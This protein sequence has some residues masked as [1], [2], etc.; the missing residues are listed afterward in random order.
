MNSK[1]PMIPTPLVAH[2]QEGMRQYL[3]ASFWS[4]TPSFKGCIDR[5]LEQEQQLFRGPYLSVKLPFATSPVP[6]DFFPHL[7]LT[8]PPYVHQRH[9]YARLMATP[10]RSTI[11]A[12]GTGSGKTESFL[13]PI[14]EHCAS[15]DHHSG[16]K[17]II[18]YPMN[19]LATDQARRIAKL[20]HKTTSLKGVR[21]G[22]YVGQKEDTPST[23]MEAN[24]VITDRNTLRADPPD[25]LL[26][27]YKM[28]DYLLLRPEDK[29]LWAKNTPQTLK[30]LVVDELHTFDGAQGTDLACLLRRLR[31]RLQV[32]K[33]QLCCV[34]T[35]ATLG[36][37]GDDPLAYPRAIFGVDFE[38]YVF[39]ESSDAPPIRVPALIGETRQSAQEFF[40]GIALCA[41]PSLEDLRDHQAKLDP[42]NAHNEEE[43]LRKQIDLWFKQQILNGEITL[44]QTGIGID[45]ESLGQLLRQL[46]SFRSLM[47][48]LADDPLSVEQAGERGLHRTH[49]ES[50]DE[51]DPKVLQLIVSSLI[52]M[53]AYARSRV[54]LS[55]ELDAEDANEAQPAENDQEENKQESQDPS[56]KGPLAPLVLTQVQLWQR[57]LRRM[58]ATVEEEPKLLFNDDQ[59]YLD[60]SDDPS[61]S[62]HLN[63]SQ[64]NSNYIQAPKALPAIRCRECGLMGWATILHK[65][66][67]NNYEVGLDAFIQAFFRNDD[68]VVYL[69]PH[70]S[71]AGIHYDK[72][73]KSLY[74]LDSKVVTLA[75]SLPDKA[76]D[77]LWVE[78][79]S[80]NHKGN[81]GGVY[82][83]KDCPLCDARHSLIIVGARSATLTSTHIN[84]LFASSFNPDK[85]LLAF[86][87]SVQD[88]AHRAGFIEARTWRFNLRIA[89]MQ[90]LQTYEQEVSLNTF[91]SDCIKQQCAH[92]G[93]L[94]FI[95][96][97]TPDNMQDDQDFEALI[98]SRDPET[99]NKLKKRLCEP[100]P[101]P[102]NPDQPFDSF[103]ELV[104]KRF[105][106]EVLAEFGHQSTRGRALPAVGAAVVSI[107]AEKLEHAVQLL[108]EQ[109]KAKLDPSHEPTK[110]AVRQ[111]VL[112]LCHRLIK[113]GAIYQEFYHDE[114]FKTLGKSTYGSFGLRR[115]LPN[116]MRGYAPTFLSNQDSR[117]FDAIPRSDDST[118]WYANWTNRCFR[119]VTYKFTDQ[120][121]ISPFNVALEVLSSTDVGILKF[122]SIQSTQQNLIQCWG[123]QLEALEVSTYPVAFCD[124]QEQ[125]F[126]YLPKHLKEQWLDAPAILKN[127][128][129]TLK[130]H[131]N[132][133]PSYFTE[134]FKSGNVQRVIAREHTGLLTRKTR[135]LTEDLFKAEP[136]LPWSP[137]LLSCTP[138][139][140]MGI[141]IGDLSSTILCSVPPTTSSFLQRIGRAGRRDGNALILTIANGRTHDQ[142][143]FAKPEEMIK[144][145]VKAPGIFLEAAAVL[146]R[147]LTAFCFDRWAQKD[148]AQLPRKM[149]FV[150]T[151]LSQDEPN[152]T[153]FPYSL[154]EYIKD[155]RKSLFDEFIK[156][157]TLES[158]SSSSSLSSSSSS[159]HNSSITADVY[160][161]LSQFIY[162]D[163]VE[164]DKQNQEQEDNEPANL[165]STEMTSPLEARI[166]NAF[167]LRKKLLHG[168]NDD[169]KVIEQKLEDL[170]AHPAPD[171]NTKKIMSELQQEIHGLKG[172]RY[173]LRDKNPL[174]DLSDEGLLPNYAFPEEGVRLKSVIWRKQEYVKNEKERYK[175]VTYEFDRP[176]A[177]ALFEFAPHSRF[178]A[179]QRAV[180]VDRIDL[181]TS[182]IEQ[183][184]FCSQCSHI[185][186]KSTVDAQCPNCGASGFNDVGQRHEML[187]IKQVYANTKDTR[188]RIRDDSDERTLSWYGRQTLVDVQSNEILFTYGTSE[189]AQHSF[190]YEYLKKCT[191]RDIN[192][193][194]YA[195]FSEDK[196]KIAGQESSIKGFRVCRS[197]GQIHNENAKDKRQNHAYSCQ[198]Q[199]PNANENEALKCLFLYREFTSEAIR[200]VLPFVTEDLSHKDLASFMAALHL[201]LKQIYRGEVSHLQTTTYSEPTGHGHHR[202]MIFTLYD[203]V[204]GGT[205]YLKDLAQPQ[206]LLEVLTKARN[207]L[208]QCS[209][210]LANEDKEPQDG[211]YRC[212]LAYKDSFKRGDQISKQRAISVLS[213]LIED[214][215]NLEEG[216][217]LKTLSVSTQLE[218]E[219]EMKF[220]Q[221][222]S[223]HQV[224]N[225][226]THIKRTSLVPVESYELKPDITEERSIK[227]ELQRKL[228]ETH[229]VPVPDHAKMRVDF[230]FT[231]PE[232]DRLPIVVFTDGIAYHYDRVGRDLLQRL[233]L[234]RSSLYDTW[235]LTHWDVFPSKNTYDYYDLIQSVNPAM[236]EQI[237]YIHLKHFPNVLAYCSQHD[238]SGLARLIRVLRQENGISNLYQSFAWLTLPHCQSFDQNQDQHISAMLKTWPQKLVDY[239][240]THGTPIGIFKPT[241]ILYLS[242]SCL[243][244]PDPNHPTSA[245]LVGVIKL[246]DSEASDSHQ[247]FKKAWITFWRFFNILQKN[248]LVHFTSDHLIDSSDYPYYMDLFE[249]G[250]QKRK[251][252][253]D[254]QWKT[255]L[256]LAYLADYLPLFDRLIADDL[257]APDEEVEELDCDLCPE[258]LWST[259]K[260]AVLDRD[261]EN[262]LDD[263]Q[264]GE[265][266]K[267]VEAEGY[268]VFYLQGLYQDHSALTSLISM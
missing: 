117:Y 128:K 116:V 144:G 42:L 215:K 238:Q 30:Y 22:L 139:L 247:E 185:S 100:R 202:R 188:S 74:R 261:D 125:Q 56:P 7:P 49:Y 167:K 252:P 181:K 235:T 137:N 46:P 54:Q 88:A 206:R 150:I 222:L 91:I 84:Q 65:D 23:S 40:A 204:P 112:G 27:N 99:I 174:N 209:C 151:A 50:G 81:N 168:Y 258:L 224:D 218:S 268:T 236:F 143:F 158:A 192:F 164:L 190:G 205:G 63:S 82:L 60:L 212:I 57:E 160:T 59:N 122:I 157:F 135:E 233:A 242:I 259:Q 182:E 130:V 21:V 48:T 90:T 214:W 262:E 113:R 241:E 223:H 129:G 170:K 226:K 217:A 80:Q 179:D 115:W 255:I 189:Q 183:W 103:L 102:K 191:F 55:L 193:G 256:K 107:N 85:R 230:V 20:V 210:S 148:G 11:V 93:D 51:A 71:R 89:L 169:L 207:H 16:V 195:E 219:L 140:E 64:L 75:H 249:Q 12:T 246:N 36:E 263:H 114:F 105:R 159:K 251:E 104:K 33:E 39:Q 94:G 67:P 138:T 92:L 196:I 9:A 110:Q 231:P 3:K 266:K 124:Q 265:L 149:A 153:Q 14:L 66:K 197:C 52:A 162:G 15:T 19:A 32:S 58:V 44:T 257:Y 13:Y 154:I 25:I 10:A 134:L 1:T 95:T 178:Y 156:L 201:G 152:M 165:I 41:E 6:A 70:G 24:K 245:K 220:I 131:P 69:F 136:A 264:E 4:H 43:Y 211:C 198:Y 199:D 244:Y 141:D 118:S 240:S 126:Y 260:V 133:P 17:A 267:L 96:A 145:E 68:R 73:S 53:G 173:S 98:K 237:I 221:S 232:K 147:Q 176:A 78:R 175:K 187:R 250:L 132:P 45:P 228:N 123:L 184:Y 216:K 194:Q 161:H 26:T 127:S 106:W 77:G 8:F 234:V 254:P 171:D 29:T 225:S 119:H 47:S 146:E 243:V 186:K 31:D 109:I 38:D 155:N 121:R 28:L 253:K 18:I 229:G 111:F 180:V 72:L 86:S 37:Q 35:S 239:V 120:K 76:D 2:L 248:P 101:N 5:F 203:M 200:F 166:I 177:R 61:N 34:G 62:S 108:K 97:F 87:D 79:V 172:L 163:S 142:Y 83:S 208:S 213:D 227:I